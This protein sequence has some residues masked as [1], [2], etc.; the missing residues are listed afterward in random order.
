MESEEPR[1][2]P[3]SCTPLQWRGQRRRGGETERWMDGFRL[4]SEAQREQLLGFCAAEADGPARTFA[5]AVAPGLPDK[6]GQGAGPPGARVD[7]RSLYI[8][9]RPKYFPWSTGRRRK[10]AAAAAAAAA[11]TLPGPVSSPSESPK[12]T[13]DGSSTGEDSEVILE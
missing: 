2:V 13:Y 10:L 11:E 7:E 9:Q 4:C 3:V 12:W 5:L 8:P 1:C 6:Q